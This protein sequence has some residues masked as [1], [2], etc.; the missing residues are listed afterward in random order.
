MDTTFT[1][2]RLSNRNGDT[3]TQWKIICSRD[4]VMTCVRVRKYHQITGH[5]FTLSSWYEHY[6]E[7][8]SVHVFYLPCHIT[9]FS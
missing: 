8:T 6:D 7:V 9:D 5:V 1:F 4:R 2:Y 3:V